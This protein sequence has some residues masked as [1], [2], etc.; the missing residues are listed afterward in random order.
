MASAP[1]TPMNDC[2][3]RAVFLR[4]AGYRGVPFQSPL[5]AYT[6]RGRIPIHAHPDRCWRA[7]SCLHRKPVH[8]AGRIWPFADGTRPSARAEGR[9]QPW[10][11]WR[12]DRCRIASGSQRTMPR[13]WRRRRT[14][15]AGFREDCRRGPGDADSAVDI[16]VGASLLK[17]K[18]ARR[19]TSNS[20]QDRF[21][22]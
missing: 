16:Q 14:R 13:C 3:N 4:E 2:I 7:P 6:S 8:G 9:P 17:N 18:S 22:Y 12:N 10:T 21:V 20:S 5:A 15:F 11:R 19:T 1:T